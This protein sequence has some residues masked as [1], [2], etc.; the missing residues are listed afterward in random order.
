MTS[1]IVIFPHWYMSAHNGIPNIMAAGADL[2]GGGSLGANKPP[3]L[4]DSFELL[5]LFYSHQTVQCLSMAV[6][7]GP[8]GPVSTGP[9]FVL[10]VMNI[11]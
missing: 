5:F 8:V 9:L 10:K 3:F 11:Q 1:K 6:A 2:G 4:P 7:T